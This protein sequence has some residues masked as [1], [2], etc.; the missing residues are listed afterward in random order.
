MT[1][2][3]SISTLLTHRRRRAG[4]PVH[5]LPRAH[6]AAVDEI[7]PAPVDQ[8]VVVMAGSSK[9][10]MPD[11]RVTCR[12]SR[13]YARIKPLEGPGPHIAT[14]PTFAATHDLE[15]SEGNSDVR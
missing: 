4:S 13:S 12:V 6:P 8:R 1:S 10:I 3:P 9:G 5:S 14:A 7:Q 11:H 2:N 15:P